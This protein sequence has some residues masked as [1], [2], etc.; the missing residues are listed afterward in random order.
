[1]EEKK[2]KSPEDVALEGLQKLNTA[3]LNRVL[4]AAAK[5]LI[6]RQLR[7]FL[8][9]CVEYPKLTVPSPNDA[10]TLTIRMGVRSWEAAGKDV[11][12]IG[13]MLSAQ[14][15]SF[16]AHVMHTTDNPDNAMLQVVVMPVPHA[17]QFLVPDMASGDEINGT[18]LGDLLQMKIKEAE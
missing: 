14:G 5:S 18:D 8:D 10:S 2:V 1:M 13:G 11:A 16:N 6:E 15:L 4:S 17:L 3:S 12:R 7:A 9:L